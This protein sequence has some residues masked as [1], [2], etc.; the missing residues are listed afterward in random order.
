M[1]KGKGGYF[2]VA[3]IALFVGLSLGYVFANWQAATRTAAGRP[4]ISGMGTELI[5]TPRDPSGA[6]FNLTSIF[7]FTNDFFHCVVV[8]NERPF[9]VRT[10]S[11]GSVDIGK[12]QFFMSVDS[13]RMENVRKTGKGSAELKGVARSIPRV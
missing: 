7:A 10:Y 1:D 2:F 8:T 12:N 3:I 6:S 13:V 4:E 11:L 9:T 5:D